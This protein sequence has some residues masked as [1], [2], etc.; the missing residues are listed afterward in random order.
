MATVRKHRGSWVADFRDKNGR[1]H[2][3]TP[4][5]PFETK[6]LQKRAARDLLFRRLSEIDSDSF[7]PIRQRLGTRL[8]RK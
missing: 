5:G 7:V 1:R 3:E 2:I 4:K 6:Q 8:V